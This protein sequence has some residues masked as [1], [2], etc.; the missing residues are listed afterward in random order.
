VAPE[1]DP[2][3][4]KVAALVEVP[5]AEGL[6][7]GTLAD[8]RIL[9]AGAVEGIVVPTSALVDDGGVTVVYLQLSGERFA[10]Q[11]VRVVER[12]GERALVEGLIAGQ[13]L[14]TVGGEAIRRS[15]LMAG[16]EAHGHVH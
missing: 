8:A 1:V 12:Q 9:L 10:R 3:H 4:G 6:V 13:R 11:P 15:S 2:A 16:G 5:A 14:V 7:L